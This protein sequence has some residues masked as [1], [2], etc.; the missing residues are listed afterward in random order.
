MRVTFVGHASVIC[1]AGDVSLWSDPWL[2]G[3]AF[4]ESWALYPVRAA[5]DLYLEIAA[6]GRARHPRPAGLCARLRRSSRRPRRNGGWLVANYQPRYRWNL[7][8]RHECLPPGSRC[9]RTNT[10][11]IRR[12]GELIRLGPIC[13]RI[14]IF[15]VIF[16]VS[17]EFPARDGS[18]LLP[19]CRSEAQLNRDEKGAILAAASTPLAPPGIRPPGCLQRA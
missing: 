3:D 11:G 16:P 17:R 7:R 5:E 8:D 14:P 12:R 19:L 15:P 4:N 10:S 6:K 2:K 9:H 1:D 13:A 18:L